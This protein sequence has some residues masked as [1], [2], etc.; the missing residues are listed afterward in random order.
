MDQKTSTLPDGDLPHL[1]GINLIGHLSGNLG[2]GVATRA[3]AALLQ[4]K[5][6]PFLVY[7]IPHG[8]S[9]PEY[10]ARFSDHLVVRPE[11]LVHPINVYAGINMDHLQ[12]L[13]GAEPALHRSNRLHIANFWWETTAFPTHWLDLLSRFDGILVMSDFIAEVCRNSIP[14]TPII[15]GEYP[16]SL[17]QNIDRDRRK[18]GISEDAVLFVA[19]FDP[20]SDP[21]RKNP[22]GII[23]AFRAAF[24]VADLEVKLVIRLNNAGTDFGRLVVQNLQ[25]VAQ[26]DSR[27]S[28]L[29]E[30]MSYDQVLSLYAC[31]DVYL[32]F[33]R[34]EGLGL[35][36]LES[37]ILG[38]AVI[39]TGWSGN[40]S[41]M[42][43]SNSALLRYRLILA[44]GNHDF[45]RPEVM[46]QGAKWAEPVLE[47]A[48]AWMRKLR[49]NPALR[50]S[51]GGKARLSAISYQR[52]AN[53]AGWLSELNDLWQAQQFLPRVTGK[54][55]FPVN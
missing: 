16:I 55:S 34:G 17:P 14:L 1:F 19:S 31:A 24:P 41:F 4:S 36:M 25:Q 44:S 50:E 8:G 11:Q 37:M 22:A 54:L 21:A 43:H 39:A 30:P 52:H 47:D 9:R 32:S 28:F 38:K 51:L 15:Y 53:D 18:F 3:I 10:D 12:M 29:L 33:H 49:N 26:D 35:G 6:V 2:L 27:I 23:S 45:Y 40:L 5:G 7:D 13:L 20:N 42:N 48:V 46:G